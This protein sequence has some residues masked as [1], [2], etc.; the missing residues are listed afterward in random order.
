MT[1]AYFFIYE[2]SNLSLEEVDELYAATTAFKS[3]K[4]N[5]EVRA[6]R[7]ELENGNALAFSDEAD[8]ADENKKEIM[9]ETA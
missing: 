1:F 2:T 3:H 6:R 9:T 4:A 8:T 7:N 5:A